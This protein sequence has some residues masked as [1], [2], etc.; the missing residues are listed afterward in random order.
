LFFAIC[1]IKIMSSGASFGLGEVPFD[2]RFQNQRNPSRCQRKSVSGWTMKRA[3]FH[4]WTARVSS[5]S[6]IRS[7][8]VHAGR[9]TC[10]RRMISCC[11]NSAFSATNCDLLLKR[12]VT[13]PSMRGV[14]SGL[15]Q[16]IMTEWSW[17][18]PEVTRDM[19]ELRIC[20]TSSIAPLP[21]W[22]L[23]KKVSVLLSADYTLVS[24]P[25]ARRSHALVTFSSRAH[26][27]N[28][29]SK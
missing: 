9:L 29:W 10:L 3:C 24:K 20:L 18:K 23:T 14:L 1:L 4:V 16:C 28:G 13:V 27:L 5:T 2:L 21:R 17:W 19:R 15:V 11:R 25:S 12:S 7:A 22:V 26:F 8:L 6:T